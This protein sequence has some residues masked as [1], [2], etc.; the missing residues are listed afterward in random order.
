MSIYRRMYVPG[1]TYF[2]TLV[3]YQ[4]KPL[5]SMPENIILLR[6]ATRQIKS[7]NVVIIKSDRLKA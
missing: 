5:F 2:F 3:T 6:Q 7:A 4:R 1:G